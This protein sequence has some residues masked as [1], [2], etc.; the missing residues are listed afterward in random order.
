M[1]VRPMVGQQ[2]R[3]ELG[4]KSVPVEVKA[5]DDR[6]AKLSIWKLKGG[7]PTGN[8][9]I[10]RDIFQ[11][12]A[13]WGKPIRGYSSGM[14]RK[15]ALAQALLGCSRMLLLDEPLVALDRQSRDNLIQEIARRNEG[16]GDRA[17]DQ[18]HLSRA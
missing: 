6:L 9:D 15:I 16:G 2:E 12:N 7:T 3:Q 14:R 17:H 11:L 10:V 18:S 5:M 4:W 13:F 8:A 1:P